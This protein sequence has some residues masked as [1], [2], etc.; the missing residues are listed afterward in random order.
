MID[1]IGDDYD[2]LIG[3]LTPIAEAI[4]TGGG[5]PPAEE[6]PRVGLRRPPPTIAA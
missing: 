5:Y 1:R 6:P 4:V 3:L 2:E